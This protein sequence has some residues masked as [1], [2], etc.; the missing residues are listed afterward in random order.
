[1]MTENETTL[2]FS[3]E[4]EKIIIDSSKNRTKKICISLSAFFVVMGLIMFLVLLSCSSGDKK[5][6]LKLINDYTYSEHKQLSETILKDSKTNY[7]NATYDCPANDACKFYFISSNSN[8]SGYINF[9]SLISSI[10]IDGE[11]VPVQNYQKFNTSGARNVIIEFKEKVENLDCFF[12]NCDYLI[13]VDFSNFDTSE[14]TNMYGLFAFCYNLTSITW[15]PYFSTSK[16]TDMSD[17][18]NGCYS[19]ELLD[20][21]NFNTAKV[22]KF[23]WMFYLC[24]SLKKLD[25]SSFDTSRAT[26]FSYMFFGCSSLTSIDLS[27]FKTSE[28]ETMNRMFHDCRSLKTINFGDNFDTRN[29]KDMGY[30]F[31]HCS[32]LEAFN[33]DD[34]FDTRNVNNMNYMFSDCSSLKTISF[35]NNFDTSNVTNMISM[36]NGCSSLETL[37]LSNFNTTALA[38]AN[39][40]FEYC[41]NLV[42]ID[43]QFT[44]EKWINSERMFRYCKKLKKIDLWGIV[45]KNLV[46]AVD[47]F[48]NCNSL[49]FIDIR[50]LV[51]GKIGDTQNIFYDLPENGYLIYDSLKLNP[52]FLATLPPRWTKIDVKFSR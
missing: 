28:V 4:D 25:I 10:T 39:S 8:S 6:N 49:N 24:K 16:V 29:V 20:L 26:D 37:D 31:C 44:S 41:V 40:M 42:K 9:T 33:F 15:G 34:N 5:E 14:L 13:S 18:F 11:S 21:S 48:Y 46:N 3:T 17:L 38:Y 1:M 45:A 52:N 50:N 19:L 12:Q 47:M 30:M 27:S 7:I 36:F 22:T 51:A 43:I 2:A 23:S 32:S 35:G